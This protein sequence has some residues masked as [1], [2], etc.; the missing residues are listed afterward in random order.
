MS[1]TEA[2]ARQWISA[3]L[4]FASFVAGGQDHLP[5]VAHDEGTFRVQ[6][7]PAL[8]VSTFDGEIRIEAWDRS[9]VRYHAEKRG[10][11]Q[12]DL[13]RIEIVATQTGDQIEIHARLRFRYR[14]YTRTQANLTVMVP[15]RVNLYAHTGDGRIEVRQVTGDIELSSGD[16]AIVA[17]GLSGNLSARTGDGALELIDVSGRVQAR[18]GDGRIQI[19]GQLDELEA[20]TGDGA[21][22][23]T[24]DRGSRVKTAWRL[25]TGDGN[26]LLALPGDLSAELDVRTHD[27]SIMTELP[28]IITG[29]V[30][31]TLQGRLNQGGN[32]ITVRTGDGSI[33]LRRN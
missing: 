30:G 24:V 19:R 31:R 9:E 22:E 21:M 15:R 32:T 27:G 26:I 18:T 29:K 14:F 11:T 8:R 13:E 25:T 23:I 12:K 7:T 33:T 17:T 6:A 28:I 5:F 4:L 3:T 16:G 20:T 10:R 1:T 2:C